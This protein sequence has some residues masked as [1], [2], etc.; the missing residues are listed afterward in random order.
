MTSALLSRLHER[1]EGGRGRLLEGGAPR[2]LWTAFVV[3][4][5]HFEDDRRGP[6][7]VATSLNDHVALVKMA[8]ASARPN[9]KRTTPKGGPLVLKKPAATYSPGPLRAKYH[10]R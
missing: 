10:R 2:G 4:R 5:E 8:A 9:D 3:H 7:L 1:R 6:V